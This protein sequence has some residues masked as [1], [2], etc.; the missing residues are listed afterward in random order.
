MSRG[1]LRDLGFGIGRLRPGPLNAITDVDG[2]RVGHV[3]LIED[4]PAIVRTG[5]TAIHP[6]ETPYWQ[7]N[8]FAGVHCLNGFGD[9]TGGYWIRESGLLTSPILLGS[10]FSLG[11]LRDT[12]L[13]HPMRA[14]VRARF[15]QPLCGE[16]NDALLND[17]LAQA[18]KPEHVVAALDAA[19]DGPVAEGGVGG[20][21]GMVCHEFKGGI[22]TSSRQVSVQGQAYTVGVLAQTNYGRRSDLRVDGVPVGLEIGYDAAPSLRRRDE[23][24]IIMVL[25]TD[26][27]LL[28]P[29]CARLARRAALGL[30]RVGG[31]GGNSSGDL[32]VAFSTGNR[33]PALPGAVVGGLHMLP[34][35]QM[36]PLIHAAVEASE[37]AIVNS[38]VAA[39]TMQGKEGVV[40]ALP[41]DLLCAAMVRHGRARA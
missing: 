41:H 8:V 4:G 17:G 26:A 12:M 32:M 29:Q 35:D 39:E 31:L 9:V 23:G 33:V 30:G 34:N 37:E 28:P 7:D 24:S 10:T 5:V 40:H 13:A 2:V 14:G 20:G 15:H 6:L 21:T 3:T 27:P 18:L 38:M 16:T 1:R 19:R 36:D 25:A 22:G 11:V